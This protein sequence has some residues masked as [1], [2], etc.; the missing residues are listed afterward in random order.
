MEFNMERCLNVYV[1]RIHIVLQTLSQILV[2]QNVN[3]Y[4]TYELLSVL[5]ISTHLIHVHTYIRYTGAIW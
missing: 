5:I 1:Y 3:I 4:Y 2:I